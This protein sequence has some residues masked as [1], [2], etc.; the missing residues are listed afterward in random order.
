MFC[1]KCGRQINNDA[2]FCT[3]CG[4]PTMLAA[5]TSPMPA[6]RPAAPDPRNELNAGTTN[7]NSVPVPQSIPM[8][9]EIYDSASTAN[10]AWG[11]SRSIPA[12][13]TE[14]HTE[15]PYSEE[16]NGTDTITR[17]EN[18]TATA[19]ESL[20]AAEELV[21]ENAES[22]R[23]GFFYEP[24]QAEYGDISK[25]EQTIRTEQPCAPIQPVQPAQQPVFAVSEPAVSAELAAAGGIDFSAPIQPVQPAEG[26]EKPVKYYTFGHIALCLAAVGV[27]AVVAGVFAGLYFSVI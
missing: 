1:S 24:E 23:N 22:V 2:L 10:N 4:S 6:P 19:E 11:G 27:M 18:S 17:A 9:S 13:N 14:Y 8:S 7:I 3:F 25:A 12:P 16:A 5:P 15:A 21:S 20:S 26:Y